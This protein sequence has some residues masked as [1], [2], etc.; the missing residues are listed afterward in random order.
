MRGAIRLVTLT[1]VLLAAFGAVRFRRG[2]GGRAAQRDPPDD[3]AG[4]GAC[5]ADCSLRQAVASVGDGGTVTLPS[6]RYTLA[7]GQL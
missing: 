3:P 7:L 4:A 5:P 2:G 1:V 6:G